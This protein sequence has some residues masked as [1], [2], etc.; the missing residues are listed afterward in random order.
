ME[1][2]PVE[3]CCSVLQHLGQSPATASGYRWGAQEPEHVPNELGALRLTCRTLARELAGLSEQL[4]VHCVND[5]PELWSEVFKKVSHIEVVGIT[6]GR[7]LSWISKGNAQSLTLRRE[8]GRDFHITSEHLAQVSRANSLRKLSIVGLVPDADLTVL[9]HTELVETNITMHGTYTTDDTIH[10]QLVQLGS[11]QSL[12]SLT[13]HK[14]PLAEDLAR[15][16]KCLKSINIRASNNPFTDDHMIA[17]GKLKSLERITVSNFL[18]SSLLRVTD[19]GLEALHELSNLT[20]VELVGSQIT[21][22][23]VAAL[24][25]SISNP[26]KLLIFR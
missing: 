9:Q 2:L 7:D 19:R 20:L 15:L 4:F 10:R 17:L 3:V 24:R 23:G 18:G 12:T 6:P 1:E 14:V 11:I 21:R 13:L 25:E 5:P 22:Q 8:K 16:P 26:S